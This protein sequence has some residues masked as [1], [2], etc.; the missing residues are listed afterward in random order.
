MKSSS[1]RTVRIVENNDQASLSTAQK[2]FNKLIKK[3]DKE[4]KLLEIWQT[5]IP[6]YQQKYANEFNPQVQTFNTLRAE[7][8][9]VFDQA[10]INKGFSKNDKAKLRDIICTIAV[11]LIMENDNDDLK[12]IYNKHSGSDFDAESEEEETSIKAFMESVLG[13]ELGDEFDLRSPEKTMAHFDEK[14]REKIALHEQL[15]QARLEQQGKRKKSAKVLA[16]EAKQQEETQNISQSIREVYRKLASALHPDR[17]PDMIERERKNALMQRVNVAYDAKDLLQLLELQLEIEQIDQ[18]TINTLTEER[19]KYYNK[20]LMG[21]SAELRQEVSAIRF[22]FNMRFD[23]PP[24]V[25]SPVAVMH[26]LE[27]DIKQIKRDIESLKNDLPLF[28]D[29]KNIKRYLKSYQISSQPFVEEGAFEYM[30]VGP[31]FNAR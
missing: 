10:Y 2:M 19:L 16:K 17:E 18:L 28:K 7:L 14:M 15:E 6:L 11:E 8:V 24:D 30:G 26:D 29:S 31:F 25:S 12:Q 22:A 1:S 27:S 3:I 20:I 23:I 4:R 21:Q 13:I 5:T 9:R